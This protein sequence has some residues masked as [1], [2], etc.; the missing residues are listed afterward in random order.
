M[1]GLVTLNPSPTC[2]KVLEGGTVSREEEKIEMRRKEGIKRRRKRRGEG[3]VV[4][5][6]GEG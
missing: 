3:I 2:C 4:G 1:S 5:G 6:L